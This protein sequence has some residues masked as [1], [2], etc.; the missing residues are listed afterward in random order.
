M[1]ARRVA[2]ETILVP[3]QSRTVVPKSRAAELY[4]LNES[5][6]A[7]WSELSEPR[8]MEE[9]ARKLR[10]TFEVSAETAA[11]DVEEFIKSMLA[12]DAVVHAQEG[13]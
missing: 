1:I 12:I 8:T 4:V 13:P 3:L 2:G 11:A 6:E 5:G 7:L 9:L 10:E